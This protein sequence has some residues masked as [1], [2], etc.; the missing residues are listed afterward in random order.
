MKLHEFV[1]VPGVNWAR[2]AVKISKDEALT[3]LL[4]V[5]LLFIFVHLSCVHLSALKIHSISQTPMNLEQRTSLEEHIIAEMR[6]QVS[7]GSRSY[8]QK[9]GC[10]YEASANW[11]PR[12]GLGSCHYKKGWAVTGSLGQSGLRK[13]VTALDSDSRL[14]W[15]IVCVFALHR[16]R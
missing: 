16:Q 5:V 7:R 6:L 4:T 15:I 3:P 13:F 14:C 2:F 12:G 11:P 8:L 9:L 10:Q 1:R